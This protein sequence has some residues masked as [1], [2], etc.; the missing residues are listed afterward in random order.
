MRLAVSGVK[1]DIPRIGCEMD[2]AAA[3]SP[4]VCPGP[5]LHKHKLVT[6]SDPF[7]LP[8][9]R[10]LAVDRPGQPRIVEV[11][12]DAGLFQHASLRLET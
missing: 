2:V 9:L 5:T 11:I 3:L 1:V 7:E 6:L 8:S 12:A 10:I 4:A